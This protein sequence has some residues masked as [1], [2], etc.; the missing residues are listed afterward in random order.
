MTATFEL[1]GSYELTVS[2][3]TLS[4]PDACAASGGKGYVGLQ[5]VHFLGRGMPRM[6]GERE[7]PGKT[8]M[9]V[10]IPASQMRAVASALLSAA[11]EARG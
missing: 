6:I 10:F 11:T 8:V 7:A 2:D 5:V 9:Q 3:R 1:G 4:G